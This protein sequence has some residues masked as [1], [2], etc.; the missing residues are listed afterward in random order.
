[1]N[2]V[3]TGQF[4]LYPRYGKEGKI[5]GWQGTAELLLEGKD[6]ALVSSTAGKLDSLTMSSAA[7]SLSRE[8]RQLLEKEVEALAMAHG[9]R[10]NAFEG[11]QVI[12]RFVKEASR[13]LTE[14]SLSCGLAHPE[15][16]P[17]K[18]LPHFGGDLI[19]N[20]ASVFACCKDGG[21][22]GREIAFAAKGQKAG[23]F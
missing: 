5:A 9:T 21:M 19:A 14:I 16:E 2:V 11:M 7:F 1:M 17:V 15:I 3:R 13:N 20:L 4:S 12:D 22:D 23:L 10:N 8:A 6:F 18:T